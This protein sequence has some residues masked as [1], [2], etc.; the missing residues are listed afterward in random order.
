MVPTR[1]AKNESLQFEVASRDAPGRSTSDWIRSRFLRSRRFVL[2]FTIPHYIIDICSLLFSSI[3]RRCSIEQSVYCNFLGILSFTFENLLIGSSSGPMNSR[4]WQRIVKVTI[5]RNHTSWNACSSYGI[6]VRWQSSFSFGKRANSN[7]IGL[8][9]LHRTPVHDKAQ[10]YRVAK[11]SYNDA[12]V[13]MMDLKTPEFLKMASIHA[14]DLI[15]LNAT[16]RQ[17]RRQR[18]KPIRRMQYAIVPRDSVIILCLG[19]VRAVAGLESVFLL[20]AHKPF[21][22]D[23][24]QELAN[25]FGTEVNLH[26]EPPELVFLEHV[27]KDTVDSFQRRLRWLEPIVDSFL[28]KV[29]D[30]IY[31]DTGVHLLVPLKD[32]L[33]AFDIVVKK[34][35]DCITEL[36]NNDDE[37]LDLLLTEQASAHK[38]GSQV[39]FSRH[40]HVELL[41]GVYARQLGTIAMELN[42]LLGRIQSK[43]EFVAL[44]LAGY[45]NRMIRMNVHI[46][47]AG[48]TLGLGTTVAGFYGMNVINGFEESAVAFYYVVLGSGLGG[49]LVA[50]S[51][52]SYLNGKAVRQRAAQRLE[53]IEALSGALS[54]LAAV[55]YTLKTTVERGLAIDKE[56]FSEL[57]S[58]VRNTKRPSEKEIDLLF[59]AFDRTKDGQIASDDFEHTSIEDV[60]G[61]PVGSDKLVG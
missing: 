50:T 61:K 35:L 42:Y 25:I 22:Q 19:N 51:S 34:N 60:L 16:S 55:D 8:S 14:R 49:L 53:E 38:T 6:L 1:C 20:D 2:R 23:F 52:L 58:K 29:A 4:G 33:Q 11:V 9:S 17:D 30:E 27:L 54:D 48:L 10:T 40:E 5:T 32:A 59:E 56:R 46:G 15:T 36:L 21:V 57:L 12:S 39:E 28:E 26:G 45:R 41:F 43:Q 37:M 31:S 44:A 7:S 18:L 13:K 3:I 47:I 24:A